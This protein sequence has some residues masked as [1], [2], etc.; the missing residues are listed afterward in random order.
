M[1]PP[2]LQTESSGGCATLELSGDW[3]RGAD[4][5]DVLAEIARL[6]ADNQL[7]VEASGVTAW[8]SSFLQT[9]NNIRRFAGDQGI[10]LE[11]NWPSGVTRLLE[12]AEAVPAQPSEQPE[13]ASLA[14]LLVFFNPINA[15]QAI[16]KELLDLANVF[17]DI[18]DT[19][20]IKLDVGVDHLK[21]SIPD[22]NKSS[23]A[24]QEKHFAK[25]EVHLHT[26]NDINNSDPEHLQSLP[27]QNI[28]ALPKVSD[29]GNSA[30]IKKMDLHLAD[31]GGFIHSNYN[32]DNTAVHTT[33]TTNVVGL[34]AQDL[35][36]TPQAHVSV[37]EEKNS[38]VK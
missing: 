21:T 31:E 33:S 6:P 1:I 23:V 22:A 19:F 15:S 24:Q 35:N 4:H 30:D 5:P 26:S 29:A 2:A 9:A 8:D 25:T 11:A 27:A 20:A 3:L 12:L 32:G 18:A 7:V 34:S 28:L 16:G 38:S 10:V 37:N 36:A 17:V 14:A 13:Q